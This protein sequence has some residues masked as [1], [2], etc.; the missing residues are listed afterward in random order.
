MNTVSFI[1]SEVVLT[2]S[3][4]GFLRQLTGALCYASQF[5]SYVLQYHDCIGVTA[6]FRLQEGYQ[7]FIRN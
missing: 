7:S 6:V 2:A 1:A 4:P 5:H 3:E